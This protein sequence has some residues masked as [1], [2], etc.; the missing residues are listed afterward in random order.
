MPRTSFENFPL[1]LA[2]VSYL[3]TVSVY[4]LGAYVLS[5]TTPLTVAIYLASCA[6]FE[7][8]L[9]KRS[10]VHCYYSGKLCGRGR[11]KHLPGLQTWRPELLLSASS[12]GG[13]S[14]QLWPRCCR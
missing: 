7:L 4:G 14:P 10:C 8:L 12:A 2:I 13:A 5:G 11:G 3:L 6:G 9:L 1:P